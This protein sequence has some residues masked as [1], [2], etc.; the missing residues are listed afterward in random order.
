[1]ISVLGSKERMTIV[2]FVVWMLL[3]CALLVV[4]T[5]VVDARAIPCCTKQKQQHC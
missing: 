1:M 2:G 5:S 4:G 3:C